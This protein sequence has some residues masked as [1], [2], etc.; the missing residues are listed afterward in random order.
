LSHFLA[1]SL[2]VQQGGAFGFLSGPTLEA[3]GTPNAG[4]LDQ[5]LALE[6]VQKYIHLFGGDPNRVTVFGQSAGAGSIMHQIT[7]YGGLGSQAPFQQAILQSPG[8]KPSPGREEQEN[9]TQRYLALLNVS[10]ISAARQ[11]PLAALS[12]ANV[13]LV[14]S[15]P[16]GTFTFAPAVA[17]SFVPAL[18][19]ALLAQG[20]FDT[21]VKIMT[22]FN[23]HETL[24]F[25]NPDNTNNS[26]FE[27]GIQDTFP[28]IQPSVVDYIAGTLYPPVFNGSYPYTSYFERAELIL[29]ESAFTCN[30]YFLHRAVQGRSPTYGYRFSVPPAYHGEDVPYTY[31]NGPSP[32][33]ANA[34]IAEAMQS[35]LTRFALS[36]N[37]NGAGAVAL[38]EYW[39]GA[40]ILDLNV[41]GSSVMPDPNNNV[42]CRWWQE[43]LYY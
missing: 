23:A 32:S 8:F 19:G 43:A 16:Y 31:F 13:E 3:S 5:R 4:L 29:A 38:P 25:T 9:L 34:T 6:W 22:G 42:R 14:A 15:S 26:I 39:P 37:P 10:S 1:R 28:G 7:A 27:A 17:G 41:T 24:Y 2:T 18:P 35:Y 12:A 11:L 30:T 21:S 20:L 33:V 36:G 40:T